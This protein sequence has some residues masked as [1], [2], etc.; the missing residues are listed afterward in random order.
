MIKLCQR[1]QVFSG[2]K[3]TPTQAQMVFPLLFWLLR[4]VMQEL[5]EDCK[6]IN[7]YFHKR[8]REVMI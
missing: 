4:D 7:D 8:V 6:D 5:P 2:E 3:T 1:I